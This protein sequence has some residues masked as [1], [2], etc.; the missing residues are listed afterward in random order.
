M[1]K[2]LI[3]LLCLVAFIVLFPLSTLAVNQ[4]GDYDYDISNGK[5]IITKYTGSGGNVTIPSKLGGYPVTSI[6]S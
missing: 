4:E 1:K 5:A 2:R 6:G 3:F